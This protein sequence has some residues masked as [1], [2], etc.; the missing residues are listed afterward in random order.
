MSYKRLAVSALISLLFIIV[1]YANCQSYF[2]PH[3]FSDRT[4]ADEFTAK[5]YTGQLRALHEPSLWELSEKSNSNQVYRFLWLRSFH[6]PISIRLD[7]QPDGNGTLTT[8]I[9]DGAGGYAPGKIIR[10]QTRILSSPTISEFL[11]EISARHYWDMPTE[12]PFNG[13]IGVD[14]AQWILEG[15]NRNNYKIV[16]RWSPKNGPIK[17]LCL[18]MVNL[19]GLKLKKDEIY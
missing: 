16:D 7:I 10:D 13:T 8:K 15:V 19:A 6:H 4:D 14:G 2:P 5:W 12:E 3:T 18:R 17:E 9:C 11:S 1:D